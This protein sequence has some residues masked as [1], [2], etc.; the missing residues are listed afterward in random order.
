MAPLEKC[1]TIGLDH[2]SSC[3]LVLLC[4]SPDDCHLMVPQPVWSP[5]LCFLPCQV[6]TKHIV[7]SCS[8]WNRAQ[9]DGRW[10]PAGTGHL[11]KKWSI[12]VPR[13]EEGSSW[14]SPRSDALHWAVL[15]FTSIGVV[16]YTSMCFLCF[17]RYL[18]WVLAPQPV[19]RLPVQCHYFGG[20][21]F[22][23]FVCHLPHFWSN[24]IQIFFSPSHLRSKITLRICSTTILLL[25]TVDKY[26]KL[27]LIWFKILFL[28]LRYIFLAW[29]TGSIR[30][31]MIHKGL[32]CQLCSPA[33]AEL[34]KQIYPR[35]SHRPKGYSW[36]RLG[37]N[38]V[39]FPL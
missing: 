32:I 10:A 9:A 6:I 11:Q 15:C 24:C 37:V 39:E 30:A 7:R 23:T 1:R 26:F 38:V 19:G 35:P 20:Q 36:V 5:A 8:I 27:C 33:V 31:V 16:T 18:M 13:V 4:L 17:W 28:L 12:S 22:F 25:R 14:I 3:Q 29:R 34:G 21:S 2:V